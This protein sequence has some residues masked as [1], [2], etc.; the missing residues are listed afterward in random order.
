MDRSQVIYLM[1]ATGSRSDDDCAKRLTTN[2]LSQWFGNLQGKR[3]LRLQSAEGPCHTAT[4]CI[5]Q[6]DIALGQPTR[7]EREESRIHE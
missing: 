1:A 4:T 5:Q 7:Q 2:G 3:I 6:C